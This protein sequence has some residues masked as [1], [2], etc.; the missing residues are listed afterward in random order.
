MKK[1][2]TSIIL[3]AAATGAFSAMAETALTVNLKNGSREQYKLAD[4]PSVTVA[5]HQMVVSS[6]SLNC[7]YNFEDVSHFNF[8]E[9][10]IEQTVENIADKVEFSF[11][12]LDNA[13]VTIATPQLQWATVYTLSGTQVMTAAADGNV[14]TLDISSLAPGVYLVAPSCHQAVKIIKK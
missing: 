1:I 11:T 8:E 7:S 4:T 12:Y 9:Y 14:V 5:D 13:T 3:A 2:I 6:A 10:K